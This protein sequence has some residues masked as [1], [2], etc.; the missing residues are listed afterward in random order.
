MHVGAV[1][2]DRQLTDKSADSA[3]SRNVCKHTSVVTGATGRTAVHAARTEKLRVESRRVTRGVAI[4]TTMRKW[5][6]LF[7]IVTNVRARFPLLRSFETWPKMGQSM[8]I[9]QWHNELRVTL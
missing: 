9:P 1:T 4:T 6:L 3:D 8:A 2:T 7:I 5:K